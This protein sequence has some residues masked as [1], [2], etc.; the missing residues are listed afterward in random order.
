LKALRCRCRGFFDRVLNGD[1]PC[2]SLEGAS[3]PLPDWEWADAT[4]R[5][6]LSKS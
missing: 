5:G 2:R 6:A 3:M 4:L 1:L